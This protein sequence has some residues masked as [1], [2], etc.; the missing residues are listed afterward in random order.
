[1]REPNTCKVDYCGYTKPRTPDEISFEILGLETL[2]KTAEQRISVLKQ[3]LFLANT[4]VSEISKGKEV[5]FGG[6][7]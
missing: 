6:D 3:S 7:I 4:V 2:I 5:E 1:M